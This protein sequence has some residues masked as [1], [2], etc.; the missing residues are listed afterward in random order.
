MET[1]FHTRKTDHIKSCLLNTV[2][3]YFRD[4]EV[5]GSNPVIP[6]FAAISRRKR[7]SD[8]T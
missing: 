5:A 3:S 6:T 7:Q 8:T 4:V 1:T 2:D